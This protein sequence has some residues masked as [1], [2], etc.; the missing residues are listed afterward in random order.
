MWRTGVLAVEDR[1]SATSAPS[2][3]TPA[4]SP[5]R[6][7]SY[8]E[9]TFTSDGCQA[10]IGHTG[11]LSVSGPQDFVVSAADVPAGKNGL[12]VWGV[13]SGEIYIGGLKPLCIT[14]P[15][16]RTSLQSS[17][18]VAGCSGAYD[19]TLTAAEL[20]AL[21]LQPGSTFFAQYWFRDPAQFFGG[22]GLSDGLA[23]AL[24]P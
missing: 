15:L 10:S 5:R 21:G 17:G 2:P 24:A 18:G 13:Q 22:F 16:K 14:P 11:T 3:S 1:G 9:P 8:C 20:Q 12:L 4:T 6:V 23:G 7:A 19:Y